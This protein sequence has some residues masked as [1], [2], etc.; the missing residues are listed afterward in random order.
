MLLQSLMN[1]LNIRASN[2]MKLNCNNKIAISVVQN[3][4]NMAWETY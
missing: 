2:N 3:A 4:F 1:N